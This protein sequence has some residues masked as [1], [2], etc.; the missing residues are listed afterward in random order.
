M[1]IEIPPALVSAMTEQ[2]AVLF[3]GAGASIGAVHPRGEKIPTGIELRD[4]LCD[5]FLA[6]KLKHRSLSEV[7]EFAV[8]ETSLD[9]VQVFVADVFKDFRAAE[10]HKLIP[11]FRWHAIVTTNIDLIIESAYDETSDRLQQLIPFFK[12]GQFVETELKKF[13]FPL[14]YLK[15]H[16][17]IAHP[18]DRDVPF[19]LA[20]S[21]MPSGPNSAAASLSGSEIGDENFPS[22]FAAI[23]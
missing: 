22:S 16:G 10:F 12:N 3:L 2:R 18:H 23:Q 19:I 6:G 9:E 5:R 20:T 15:L 21:S 4:R 17:C 8:N 11:A 1:T 14:Q 13:P 7:T